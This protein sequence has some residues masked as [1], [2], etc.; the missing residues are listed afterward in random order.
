MSAFHIGQQQWACLF[1]R[2]YFLQATDSQIP[3]S[4]DTTASIPSWGHRNW[5]Q[6]NA[7]GF[8]ALGGW[9]AAVHADATG[10][11]SRCSPYVDADGTVKL[12]IKVTLAKDRDVAAEQ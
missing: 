6:G 8:A 4:A 3:T 1:N 11:R 2:R 12:K 7:L 10:D 9:D 5:G